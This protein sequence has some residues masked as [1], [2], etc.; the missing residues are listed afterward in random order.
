MT[1]TYTPIFPSLGL[2]VGGLDLARELTVDEI[3]GLREKLHRHGLLRFDPQH[4]SAAEQER[5]AQYFGKFSR[6]GAIQKSAAGATYVSNVRDDGTFGKGELLFH[7]DQCYYPYPMKAIMLF[8][9]EVPTHAGGETLFA[10]TAEALRRLPE[11]FR[12]RLRTLRVRHAFDY[13]A[14]DYGER[15]AGEVQRFVATHTHPVIAR[16]PWSDQEILMVN[17][18]TAV[19]IE[20]LPRADSMALLD[21]INDAIADPRY[22]YRHRWAK[23]DFLFWDNL[24]LQ[25]ARTDFSSGER[26][27][28]RRCALGHEKEAA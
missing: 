23:G 5:F 1:I 27:T 14:V 15:K 9:V 6:Q 20:G 28:L 8:G 7:S 22:V 21:R 17:R 10:N 18:A 19:E 13:G 16:H 4:F 2:H 24:L 25:H 12:A 3:A 26:R 11:D